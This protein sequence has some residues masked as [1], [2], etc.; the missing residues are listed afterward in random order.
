MVQELTTITGVVARVNENGV[1][2]AGADGW[3]TIS[4]YADPKPALPQIGDAVTIG[5]DK[6]GFARTI[7]VD[8]A[9]VQQ[10]NGATGPTGPIGPTRDTAITRLACLKSAVHFLAERSE[11]KSEHV[12]LLAERFEGWVTRTDGEREAAHEEH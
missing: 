2:L 8:G 3:L 10:Q 12:L 7:G 11:A 9:Q 1:K 5:L 6:S 4:R